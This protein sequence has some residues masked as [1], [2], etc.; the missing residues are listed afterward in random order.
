MKYQVDN[1]L[2]QIISNAASEQKWFNSDGIFVEICIQWL[3]WHWLRKWLSA[4]S[5]PGSFPEAMATQFT[6][7]YAHF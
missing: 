2:Q 7:E 5:A 3:K 6:N 4:C 1:I